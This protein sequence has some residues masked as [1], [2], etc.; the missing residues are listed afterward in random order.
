MQDLTENLKKNPA[1]IDAIRTGYVLHGFNE[2][3][4]VIKNVTVI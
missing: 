1:I 2:L 4:E 3:V